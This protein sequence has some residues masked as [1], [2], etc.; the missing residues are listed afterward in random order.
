MRSHNG[1]INEEIAQWRVGFVF[2]IVDRFASKAR[3]FPN[4]ESDDKRISS[5]QTRLAYR[6][7]DF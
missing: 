3:L 2:E 4:G 5:C 6:A 7:K 1:R